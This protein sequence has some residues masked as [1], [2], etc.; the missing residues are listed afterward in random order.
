MSDERLLHAVRQQVELGRLVPLGSAADGAWLAERAA[1]GALRRAV[2]AAVPAARV[3]ELRLAVTEPEPAPA[4]VPPPASALPPGPLA[5]TAT[6]AAPVHQPLPEYA[7]ALRLALAQAA[8]D[9]LGLAVAT[10]DLRVAGLIED[11]GEAGGPEVTA[12]APGPADRAGGGAVAAAVR[13]V[14]GV[15]ALPHRVEITDSAEPPCRLVRLVLAVTDGRRVL[16]VVREARLAA[17]AAA[18]DDEA[19]GPVRVSAVVTDVVPD[20]QLPSAG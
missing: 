2:A 7:N 6:V 8:R 13:V 16:D 4:A 9:R 5:M 15:Y 17:A 1:A 12:T 11:A 18:L 20:G 10:I 3:E 19:P 14:P